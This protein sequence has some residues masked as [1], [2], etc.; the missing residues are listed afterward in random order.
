MV[1]V[2]DINKKLDMIED[3]IAS[4]KSMIIK[5]SQQPKSKKM[6]KLKGLLKGI[7]ISEEDIEEAKKSL[8]KVG[9]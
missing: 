5:I 7:S 2:Y 1:Q 9:A 3:E 4:L 8:L 6:L